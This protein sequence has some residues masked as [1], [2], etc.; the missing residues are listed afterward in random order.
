[1]KGNRFFPPIET[2][3]RLQTPCYIYNTALLQQTLNIAQAEATKYDYEI[4]YAIK[5]NFNP[6]LLRQIAANGLGADCVSGGEIQ[7]ALEAGFDASKIVY[8]GVGKNDWEIEMALEKEILCFN[9]E[10]LA[11]LL[12]ID[13]LAGKRSQKARIALRINPDVIAHTH[14]HI[15]T[16][17]KESKFGI[18]LDKLDEV[19]HV[20]P[21]L[22][23]IIF[24]GIH[25][26]IGSQITNLDNF[27]GL[28][29]RVN[30]MQEWLAH[31]KLLPR[32]VNLGGGLGIDYK[33]PEE[34]SI[35]DF[36]AFFQLFDKHLK[37]Y[38]GQRIHFELGRSLVAQC[39]ALLTKTLYVKEGSVKKFAIVDAGMTELIRPAL[40]QASHK[41][42]NIS[43]DGAL[44]IYDIVGPVCESTDCFGK[45][46]ELNLV[47]RHD[48]LVMYS[49]GAYG[50]SMA[51]HYNCRHLREAFFY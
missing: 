44:E 36:A 23:N 1:M 48:L 32:H 47:S 51:S 12:V 37:R 11:E 21:T 49:A 17:M 15:V 27:Y 3:N 46:V 4:H 20:L 16:G 9:V 14:H 35:P 50:E 31:R 43:S 25:F 42:E 26:H 40:Y 38:S 5:A 34:K 8:A 7:V 39:G 41:I 19:L 2:L 29:L 18:N 33:L 45:A 24:E 22:K 13:E 10:S 28:C 6:H 30:E